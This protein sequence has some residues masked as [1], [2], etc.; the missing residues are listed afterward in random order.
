MTDYTIYQGDC[1]EVL[2]T[3]PSESIHVCCTSPP[4]YGLRDY[5]TAKWEGGDA[6]H[7][8][9]VRDE[10]NGKAGSAKQGTNHG[11]NLVYSGD[12]E[13]GAV[14][15]DGQIGLEKSPQEFV[16][17][18]V[19]VFEE[20]KRVLR[21]DGTLWL[22]LGDS[23]AGS[24]KGLNGDG[25]IGVLNSSKQRSN[26]G[27]IF[28]DGQNLTSRHGLGK[29]DGVKPKD[30]IGIPWRVAF[31]LQEAG[32]YLR[33]DIIWCLS[34]GTY[35]Y[36]KTQKGVMPIMIRDL[37]RLDPATVQLW[38]GQKW[39]QLLGISKSARKGDELE[40]VLRSG[41][42][43]SCTPTHRFPTQRGLLE[44]A[45]LVKG[46]VLERCQLDDT[47]YDPKGLPPDAAWFLGLYL[48]EGSISGNGRT[49]Q[50]AGHVKEND[51][52]ELVRK[53]A[54]FYGGSVTFTENGNKRDIRVYSPTLLA[55]V[56]EYISGRT[57]HNKGLSNKCW[58]K[59]NRWLRHLLDGYLSGDGHYDVKND[60]WRLG[61]CRN[62]NLERDLRTLAARLGFRIVLNS[63]TAKN[64]TGEF[65]AFK[66][67]IR[68]N[69]PE[70]HNVKDPNE[71]AEIR[72][73]RCREVYD[74]GV[75]DEPHLF[76]L[77]SGIL[78]H[79][80]KPNPMPESVTD[81][82]TKAHEY[83]FLLTKQPRYYYDNEA[84]KEPLAESSYSRLAQDIE[85]QKGSD[86][87]PFKTNGTMKAVGG[88]DRSLPRN[89]N[90]I[91]G[92]LDNWGSKNVAPKGQTP[93]SFHVS[94]LD[95][96]PDAEY[97]NRNKRSV[98]TV[99]TKP[100]SEAHFA[101][102]PE[103]LI[104]PCILAGSRKGDVVLDPFNGAGTTGLVS[105]KNGRE[106]I[107]IELNPEYIEITERRL[108]TIQTKLF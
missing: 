51:R 29:Q 81:R 28:A 93:N 26:A 77:A 44:A 3:L 67:E 43:I 50:I 104:E 33:Q 58:Q 14:R 40:I 63:V 41:E 22:N 6:L 15:V 106:Y 92:S 68:F 102:F 60:R 108:A 94:R 2:K 83:I 8:H 87:V 59:T 49:I 54:E 57:A 74:L 39:T 62:Y 91:T 98:W 99:T 90:G 47:G 10:R 20:V 66:G 64:Q 23:Y 52:L 27:S 55:I 71:I 101:T 30:L 72:K 18:L 46:D 5:G 48:A 100:Y 7:A 79:N 19:A 88:R 45:A 38:N 31:A 35:V 21:P 96:E 75:E 36:A 12:C 25:S 53:V 70:H 16:A 107:G 17:A 76:A 32:W 84:I 103:K 105:L 78:T 56:K 85:S 61:F 97:L 37:A 80:S 11:A 13:C 42:R 24:G 89:R 82:C 69:I 9:R 4:Y 86:R 95:G 65:P 73:A 34:G 1:L